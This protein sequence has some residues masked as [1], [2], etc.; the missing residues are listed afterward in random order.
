[1]T[2][3]IKPLL[4]SKIINE[5]PEVT[6]KQKR[7]HI[8]PEIRKEVIER[9]KHCVVCQRAKDLRV[10]HKIPYGDSTPENLVTLCYYCHEYVHKIIKRK[11]YPYISPALAIRLRGGY[12][13]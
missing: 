3:M 7:K 6:E 9:D 13:G 12:I 1:M 8:P 5:A 10:H 4:L 2:S 11:G